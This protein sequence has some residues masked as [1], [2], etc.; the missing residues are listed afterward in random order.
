ML[1]GTSVIDM[2]RSVIG[3]QKAYQVAANSSFLQDGLVAELT[4][5]VGDTVAVKPYAGGAAGTIAGI[6]YVEKVGKRYFPVIDEEIVVPDPVAPVQLAH[7]NVVTASVKVYNATVGEVSTATTH[8][9]VTTAGVLTPVDT[10]DHM[11][12]GDVLHVSYRYEPTITEVMQL[13]GQT[14]DINSASEMLNEVSVFT[15]NC[16]IYTLN[17]DTNC[18]WAVN[19]AVYI[20]DTTS[21]L[22]LTTGGGHAWAACRIHKIPTA[23]DPFLAIAYNGAY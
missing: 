20:N 14:F 13:F 23:S 19:G 4:T 16:L 5:G 7:S 3:A 18:T 2:T 10:A 9:S 11:T 8:Y 15:G 17:Y 21:L 6:A 1:I 22:T 12:A